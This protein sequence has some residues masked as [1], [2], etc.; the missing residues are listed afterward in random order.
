MQGLLNR[1]IDI[2]YNQSRNMK[3]IFIQFNL[4]VVT[5]WI[6]IFLAFIFWSSRISCHCERRAQSVRTIVKP[7]CNIIEEASHERNSALVWGE[8]YAPLRS[9]LRVDQP[10]AQ[11]CALHVR[12]LAAKEDCVRCER[13]LGQTVASNRG[14]FHE[15]LNSLIQL[16]PALRGKR[17]GPYS[18]LTG[19]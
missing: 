15:L 4:L 11:G 5:R 6:W 19:S 8:P 12:V 1:I 2:K 10:G 13:S 16:I 9:H 3:K 17:K 7:G 14:A 18:S